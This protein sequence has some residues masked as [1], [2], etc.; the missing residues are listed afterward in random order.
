M[1]S[2]AAKSVHLTPNTT[3]GKWAVGLS[4]LGL[5]LF[6]TRMLAPLIGLP[7]NYLVALLP[8]AVAGG[9]SLY[10]VWREHERS[11]AVLITLAFGLLVAFFLLAETIVA[12]GA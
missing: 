7:L 12:P 3:A 1:A 10:A 6:I 9:V 2:T 11:L 5:A 8:V 4:V